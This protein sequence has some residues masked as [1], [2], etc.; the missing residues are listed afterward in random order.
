MRAAKFGVFLDWSGMKN[1]SAFW[2]YLVAGWSGFY[3][4]VVELLSGR[5]IAPYF[6]SGVQVW[7]S[8][9]FVFMLGLA[10]GYLL[11]GLYSRRSPNLMK[12]GAILALAAV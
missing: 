6:G 7:G 9:I 3:V 2:C 12:L 10:I 1:P 11:G 5:L 8:V 4:M